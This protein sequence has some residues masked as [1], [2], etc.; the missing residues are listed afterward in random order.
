MSDRLPMAGGCCGS[1]AECAEPPAAVSRDQVRDYYAAAA[2]APQER[3]CCPT[4][5]DAADV[6]HIPAEVME[7]SY[8]C[9]SP[10]GKARPRRGDTVLDLGSGGGID[11]FIAARHVGPGGRVIGVDM[12]DDM[13]ARATASARQVARNLGY[14][15]VEFRKGFLEAV[16]VA[17]GT[18][19]LVTS[20]CVLNLSTDKG[21]V[22]GE[23]HRALRHGG[24]FVI[25]DIVSDRPVPEAMR[26]DPELWGECLSGAMTEAEFA[27]AAEAA[28]FHGVTL[29]R[30]Y[31][32]QTVN[33]I[34]FYSTTFRGYRFDKGAA[35][36]FRGHAA[37]YLGPGRAFTDDDGHT[38]PRGEAVAVCTDTA[39]RL[40]A[41]PYVGH[42]LVTDPDGAAPTGGC[43]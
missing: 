25:S 17:D 15:V 20:N 29:A 26:R 40:R 37:A 9:G 41:E 22:F 24:R 28:G 33:G 18:V 2:R 21:R 4:G 14:A 10:M 11:C 30:E 43:C 19:D 31:L 7:I 1:G 3:L 6:A 23:I 12:T 34:A 27:R 5:Y 16:P 39:D 35:C 38:F 8:G 36:D 42:F 13:L 32:W